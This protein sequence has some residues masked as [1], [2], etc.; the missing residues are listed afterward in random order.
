M[1]LKFDHLIK[2]PKYILKYIELKETYFDSLK[3][4]EPFLASR[5]KL[6][7]EFMKLQALSYQPHDRKIEEA[8]FSRLSEKK[9]SKKLS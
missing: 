2:V 1:C 3:L 7:L 9:K 5:H 8:S 4:D 6:F